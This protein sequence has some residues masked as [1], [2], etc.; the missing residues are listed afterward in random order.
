M[1]RNYF[2]VAWRNLRKHK[3]YT[4]INVIGLA[5][6]LACSILIFTIVSFHLNFDQFHNDSDRIYR[7]TSKWTGETT[8]YSPAVPQPLGKA[9]RNEFDFA[10]K[11]ARV[12]HYRNRLVSLQNDPQNRKFIEEDGVVYTEPEYFEIFNYPVL[13]SDKA[14]LLSNPNEALI[15]ENIAKKYY[16]TEDPIGKVIKVNNN[17]NF[18]IKGILKNIPGNSDRRQEIYLSYD[19]LKDENRWLAS[20]SSWGGVYSG[21]QAYTKLKPNIN[22]AQVDKGLKLI[23]NK[24]YEGRDQKEWNFVVQPLADIHFNQDLDGAADKNYLWALSIIGIFLIITA[25]VNFINLA[26][27]QAL[28]RA[29]EIGVRKVL[30]SMKSQLFWQFITETAIISMIAVF[31]AYGVAKLGLPPLNTLLE[32]NM[33]L[34]F[35]S[36]YKVPL[37]LL[38][39]TLFII[40][41]S[42]SYPGLVLARF[43]PITALKSKLS[44]KSIGGFSL[45]RVLVVTQFAISQLLIIGTIV[46]AAQMN[47]SKS[48]DLG[49]SKD[50]IV[51]LPM[52]GNNFITKQTLKNEIA[53]IPGVEKTTLCYQAPASGSNSNT[54][55]RYDNR[56]ETEHWSIN[57]K[58][59]DDKYLSTFDIPLVAGRNFFP[60]DTTKEF[61]V[62]ETFVKKLNITDPDQVLGKM[63][64]VNG[65]NI[66]APIVGVVK[67]FYNYSFRSEIAAI[68]I[69]PNND[70]YSNLA[71][72]LNA[73][74]MQSSLAAIEKLWNSAYPDYLFSREF[75]DERIERFYR[76]DT[77]MYNLIR[78]FSLIAIVIGCLGLYGLVSFM[79]VRKTK[80]IGVRKV[81]GAGMGNILWI[82]GKEFARLLL[83]AFVVAA[84]LAWWVMNNYLKEFTYRTHIGPGIFLMAIG[85]TIVIATVTVGYR[86]LRAASANPV[87]S[88][89]TE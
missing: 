80:E 70:S 22:K 78:A 72:K 34:E 35:F 59:A 28:N 31:I 11:T 30:G 66:K 45:R 14:R 57:M 23:V 50:A 76:M 42:G 62:N 19:N 4:T 20:D 84:P 39:T 41:L 26:T 77:V 12:V 3:S 47:Y 54:G 67:D 46:I 74:S 55:V 17:T 68:C 9:F 79:A 52:P 75:L 16:G 1:I 56:A 27:A 65:D 61:L 2:K 5:M 82:F 87:K 73:N 40:F 6:G 51:M 88:L 13:R 71:V 86:S 24:N 44:Q 58:Q 7:L 53:K 69:M 49:F 37:F 89:R 38:L 10:E 43:A 81:L 63:I 18:T 64:A 85:V 32:S 60:S 8:N 33:S 25:C 29:K 83:V 36:S 48:T 15:T 21:S